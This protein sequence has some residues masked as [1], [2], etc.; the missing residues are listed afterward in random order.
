MMDFFHFRRDF[1]D[2]FDG[3][4]QIGGWMTSKSFEKERILNYS[5]PE[6]L[7]PHWLATKLRCCL[8]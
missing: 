8:S 7:L 3:R 4:V 2:Y 6:R 5:T 1:Q